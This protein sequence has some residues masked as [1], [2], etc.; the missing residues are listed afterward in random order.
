M[1]GWLC[2]L[3]GACRTGKTQICHTLC[4][5]TQMPRS[6]GGG[7]GKVAYIDTEGTFRPDRIIPIAERFGVDPAAVLENVR[8]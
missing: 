4:V 8:T 1:A 3:E 5:T 2:Y 7:A 6:M